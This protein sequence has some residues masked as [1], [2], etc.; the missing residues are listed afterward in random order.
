MSATFPISM[1]DDLLKEIKSAA[2]KTDL[3]QQ[4]VVRQSIKAGLPAILAKFNADTGR[5]TNV[6][7]LPDEVLERIYSNPDR[8]DEPSIRRFIKAQPI[9]AK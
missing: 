6:D 1:P 9:N 3:S 5:I 7:P 8:D 2:R 4:D